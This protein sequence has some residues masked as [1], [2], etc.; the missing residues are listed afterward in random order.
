[1][2]VNDLYSLLI[3]EFT[4]NREFM[5]YDIFIAGHPGERGAPLEPEDIHIDREKKEIMIWVR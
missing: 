2:K 5:N 3:S 4:K 1:M